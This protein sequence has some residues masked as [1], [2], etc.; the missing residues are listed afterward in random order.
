MLNQCR[1][2]KHVGRC[3]G[4]P[5]DEC[6]EE[7]VPETIPSPPPEHVAH[8]DALFLLESYATM[9]RHVHKPR[10]LP[11]KYTHT[12]DRVAAMRANL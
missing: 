7:Q 10:R 6:Y 9:R 5:D 3:S 12:L 11:R 4:K 8:D 2:C 1:T